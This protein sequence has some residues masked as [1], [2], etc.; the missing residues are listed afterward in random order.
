LSVCIKC[1]DEEHQDELID[2]KNNIWC[3]IM[4]LLVYS[5]F[6]FFIF[7]ISFIDTDFIKCESN[8]TEVYDKMI[9][10]GQVYGCVEVIRF[11]ILLGLV[12]AIEVAFE[13]KS[14]EFI[15]A[16]RKWAK[17]DIVIGVFIWAWLIVGLI[18]NY[19]CITPFNFSLPYSALV[20]IYL[21]CFLPYFLGGITVYHR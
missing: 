10:W 8:S 3:S 11:A 1:H 14:Y 15:L 2:K 18:F 5:I 17:L 16:V 13:F 7:T 6:P 21:I 19:Y 12:I 4:I 20:C 9:L